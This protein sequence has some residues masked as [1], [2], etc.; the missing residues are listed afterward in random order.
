MLD[1]DGLLKAVKTEDKIGCV[2]RCHLI[3]ESIMEKAIASKTP[4]EA[5]GIFDFQRNRISYFAKLQICTALGM[6]LGL[7]H[8][9][10]RLNKIRNKFGHDINYDLE[11]GLID[12]LAD[13][14][15]RNKWSAC[16]KSVKKQRLELSFDEP[17]V[18][19]YGQD[20]RVDLIITFIIFIPMLVGWAA[21]GS[22][23]SPRLGDGLSK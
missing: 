8:Y 1:V 10:N 15:D 18:I 23:I 21:A 3:T 20:I 5:S 9:V 12:D 4:V 11:R 22:L 17:Q 19:Q 2:L 16:A 7:V 14:C 6:P 13:I